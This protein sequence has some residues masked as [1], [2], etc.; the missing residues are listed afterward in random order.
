MKSLVLKIS[1]LLALCITCTTL[2][3]AQKVSSQAY[4]QIVSA[5]GSKGIS[6]AEMR[7]ALSDKGIDVANM[8]EE[9]IYYRKNC[10]RIRSEEKASGKRTSTSTF[11]FKTR[12]P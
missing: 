4:N 7:D 1:F 11:G 9:E 5:L 2:V 10:C 12:Y 8:T 6:E 3:N